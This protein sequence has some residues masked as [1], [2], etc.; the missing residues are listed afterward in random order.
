M[1]VRTLLRMTSSTFKPSQSR[2]IARVVRAQ[3][4]SDGAGVR[5]KRSIGTAD[6][7]QLD[8][9][10]LL[11]EF[12]SDNASDYIAGFP[13]H[14]HR[15]FE[16]V[17]YMLAG[18][19]EHRDNMGNRGLL[20][21]GSVQWMTAGR[22]IIH[23][24]MPRQENGLMWGF[25]LWVNLAAS[26]KMTAPRYQDIPP[27]AVPVVPLESGG[28]VR[29]I[30]GEYGGVAGAVSGIATAPIYLDVRLPANAAIALPVTLGHHALAYVYEGDAWI[31]EGQGSR[32]SAHQLGVLS[33]GDGVEL[34]AAEA[35]ARL[36]IIAGRP[37]KE[38]VER[39][40]PFV[41]NTREQITQAVRDFQSGR[42]A[43]P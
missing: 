20:D 2:S 15:G 22:G 42:F 26:D 4:V 8:P 37:L 24:E 34:R 31:G 38:P 28:S 13:S 32:V 29:V 9:F 1:G 14:P 36:L 40:G 11:D 41:M 25:Q 39:Y 5:L 10:L 21:A 43:Q 23:S 30:A 18:S 16:T 35:G 7:D 17:T 27:D 33:E 12:R 6:F 3:D 19:M